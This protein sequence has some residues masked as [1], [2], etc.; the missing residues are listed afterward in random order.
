L[1]DTLDG[2]RKKGEHFLTVKYILFNLFV[3]TQISAA[4]GTVYDTVSG[5]MDTWNMTSLASTEQGTI[6]NIPPSNK[7]LFRI[8]LQH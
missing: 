5:V 7:Q 8:A 2:F 3:I 4:S 1:Y 6:W